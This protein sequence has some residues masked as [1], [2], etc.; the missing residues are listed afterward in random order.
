[1]AGARVVFYSPTDKYAGSYE[2]VTGV[3]GSFA[4]AALPSN[5][6]RVRIVPPSGSGLA[7]EWY[8]D[9]ASRGTATP[10][11]VTDTPITGIDATVG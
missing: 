9:A 4:I 3:D 1:M 6:Y 5:T 7:V 8:E 2:A 10:I 11:L